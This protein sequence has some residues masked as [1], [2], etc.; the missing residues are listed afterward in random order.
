MSYSGACTGILHRVIP[1]RKEKEKKTLHRVVPI[2]YRKMLPCLSEDISGS[3]QHC[4]AARKMLVSRIVTLDVTTCAVQVWS[5][6]WVCCWRWCS[7]CKRWCMPARWMHSGHSRHSGC[8]S[9]C[10]R[11]KPLS[12]QLMLGLAGRCCHDLILPACVLC[13]APFAP[14][15]HRLR[16]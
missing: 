3:A 5:R 2:H 15:W 13:L 4:R 10:R 8:S 12:P 1:E 7:R 14:L 6:S 11:F 16:W 9:N